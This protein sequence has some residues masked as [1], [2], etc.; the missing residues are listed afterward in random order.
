MGADFLPDASEP[1][2][3]H[4][5]CRRMSKG[6][7]HPSLC[8]QVTSHALLEESSAWERYL[9]KGCNSNNIFTKQTLPAKLWLFL[10]YRGVHPSSP[11]AC[12]WE[13]RE[14]AKWELVCRG[15]YSTLF[16]YGKLIRLLSGA[17][18]QQVAMWCSCVWV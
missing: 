15:D 12:G 1:S 7:A 10:L 3:S 2:G 13:G 16:W 17:R 4:S 14:G 6:K 8:W 9:I 18:Q 11:C 5:V